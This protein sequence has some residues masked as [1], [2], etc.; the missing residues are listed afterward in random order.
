MIFQELFKEIPASQIADDYNIFTLVGKDF[1]AITAGNTDRYN[2]MIG[3]GGGFGL[4]FRNPV[5]WCII[6]SDRY[7]L[8]LME[9]EGVYTMSYF[10]EEHREQMMFLG[11]KSGRDSDKMRESTLSAIEIS[12]GVVAFAEAKLIIACRLTQVTTPAVSDFRTL[13]TREYLNKA[14][15]IPT[16]QRQYVFGDIIHAW[17]NHTTFI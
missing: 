12:P 11:S 6:R 5:T 16:D 15:Q 1:F 17:V 4:M 8:E 14:Y 13:E 3:S 10:P 7:T 2:S 9:Q